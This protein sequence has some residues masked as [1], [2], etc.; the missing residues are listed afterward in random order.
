MG[1]GGMRKG[2]EETHNDHLAAVAVEV[3]ALELGRT[4]KFSGGR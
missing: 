3:G 4:I 1:R 2:H